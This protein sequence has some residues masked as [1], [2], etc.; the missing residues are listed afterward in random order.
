MV[1]N[2]DETRGR[3]LEG[4]VSRVEEKPDLVSQWIQRSTFPGFLL[5]LDQADLQE[6]AWGLEA[7]LCHRVH[8]R[9]SAASSNRAT[10]SAARGQQMFPRYTLFPPSPLTLRARKLPQKGG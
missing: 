3:D 8:S 9:L 10:E 6:S 1:G 5:L 7:M 4:R 2:K